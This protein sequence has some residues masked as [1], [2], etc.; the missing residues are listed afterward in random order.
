MLEPKGTASTVIMTDNAQ[1]KVVTVWPWHYDEPAL[2]IMQSQCKPVINHL[3]CL[4]PTV[5]FGSSI[6]LLTMT[7]FFET[8]VYTKS[9]HKYFSNI[10]SRF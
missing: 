8:A 6:G 7:T 2:F 4:N 10:T 5:P 1:A 3:S 9:E